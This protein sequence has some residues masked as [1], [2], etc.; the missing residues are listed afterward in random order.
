MKEIEAGIRSMPIR[1][2][3]IPLT[4]EPELAKA[5]E[6]LRARGITTEE[7]SRTLERLHRSDGGHDEPS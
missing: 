6:L 1:L 5:F 4:D 7:Y 3:D 2:K